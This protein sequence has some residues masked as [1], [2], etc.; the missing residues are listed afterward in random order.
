[1]S[2]III[3]I[4]DQF[5]QEE[6]VEADHDALRR[7]VEHVLSAQQIN[8]AS[9]SLAIVDDQAIKQLKEKYFGIAKVTDVISFDL[10]D[11][12][13]QSPPS[14]MDC[15]VVVNIN[16]AVRFAQKR[17]S[18]PQAELNLYVVHGLLHQLGFDDQTPQ[19]A[20]VMHQREDQL[21]CDLGFGNVFNSVR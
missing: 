9:I 5:N 11:D 15:E 2:K 6:N 1:M 17:Q 12:P 4:S 7:T 10:S 18:D 19:Q 13:D 20:Q 14:S 16:Q 3:T 8:D 21:L